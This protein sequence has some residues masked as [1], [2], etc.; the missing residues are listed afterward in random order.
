MNKIQIL[1]ISFFL[2][3]IS[4]NYCIVDS[5]NP[6][7]PKN[8]G[9]FSILSFFFLIFFYF[10]FF[11]WSFNL[12]RTLLM[13]DTNKFL[14]Q[15]VI[16]PLIKSLIVVLKTLSVELIVFILYKRVLCVFS[17]N[18]IFNINLTKFGQWDVKGKSVYSL[19]FQGGKCH[20]PKF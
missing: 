10:L 7:L 15:V 11:K 12:Q 1:S 14:V 4:E 13:I 2:W 19:Q 3:R 5:R 9:L 16:V 20:F 8:N 6:S 17:S 18:T